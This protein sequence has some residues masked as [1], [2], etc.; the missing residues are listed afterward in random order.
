M[1][2]IVNEFL[3]SFG[4]LR[5]IDAQLLV[6]ILLSPTATSALA[7][8]LHVSLR[9]PSL[10][11]TIQALPP[12]LQVVPIL[13]YCECRMSQKLLDH[14]IRTTFRNPPILASEDR[15]LYEDLKRLVLSDIKRPDCRRL[16]WRATPWKPSGRFVGCGR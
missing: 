1:Q 5:R 6:V 2:L 14:A 4:R 15:A 11:G 3:A 13:P 16:C 10:A 7:L 12:F 8:P 9:C